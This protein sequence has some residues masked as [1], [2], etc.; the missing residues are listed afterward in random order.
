MLVPICGMKTLI[1]GKF[2]IPSIP[3]KKLKIELLFNNADLEGDQRGGTS[4]Y[5]NIPFP[6]GKVDI[7]DVAFIQ[8]AYGRTEGDKEWNYMAD[9]VPDRIIDIQ[10]ISRATR[11]FGKL[12]TYIRDLSGVQVI[13][14]PSKI[15]A[16]P[17]EKGFIEIAPEQTEFY[18]LKNGN[19]IG[20]FVTFWK[21]V[22]LELIMAIATPLIIIPLTLYALRK[23]L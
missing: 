9:V 21:E 12:G 13:F 18:V 8:K 2:Y 23:K 19:P 15:R 5:P 1:D 22:P 3:L 6:D 4:P 17:D 10:D 14:H 16:T 7:E 20:A 11:N